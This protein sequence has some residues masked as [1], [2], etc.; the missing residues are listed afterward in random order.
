MNRLSSRV[1]SCFCGTVCCSTF[2]GVYTS[3][4]ASMFQELLSDHVSNGKASCISWESCC[5]SIML[6][7]LLQRISESENSEVLCEPFP[8]RFVVVGL[9]DCVAATG[10][11]T[12]DC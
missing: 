1:A 7:R 2:C 8:L 9:A 11:V 10:G 5:G 3:C 6:S 4:S 12:A